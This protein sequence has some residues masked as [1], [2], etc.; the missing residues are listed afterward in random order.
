MIISI[1][2]KR[3][4]WA[5]HSKLSVVIMSN[6]WLGG[7]LCQWRRRFHIG[8]IS[9]SSLIGR[10]LFYLSWLY[11]LVPRNRSPSFVT[12]TDACVS[13][14]LVNNL[15]NGFKVLSQTIRSNTGPDQVLVRTGPVQFKPYRN[16]LQTISNLIWPLYPKSVILDRTGPKE[17][18]INEGWVQSPATVNRTAKRP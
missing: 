3:D 6:D 10:K 8:F 12:I 15:L 7:F 11:Q 18:R 2:N 9:K 17:I 4:F 5:G 16:D 13:V 1:L 14:H